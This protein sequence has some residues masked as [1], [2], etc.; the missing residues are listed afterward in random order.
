VTKKTPGHVDTHRHH[1]DSFFLF[2][3][4]RHDLTG[5]SVEVSLGDEV[6]QVN[7]PSC[8][9]IPAGIK[10]SYKAIAGEGLFINSVLCDSYNDSLLEY[11]FI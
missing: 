11:E 5:L 9:F 7:S 8:V 4:Q 6:F 10:H 2:L 3:S 1:V